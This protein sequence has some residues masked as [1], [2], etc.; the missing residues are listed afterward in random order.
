VS[1]VFTFRSHYWF[2][3]PGIAT[4]LGAQAG[5]VIYDFLIFTGKESIFNKP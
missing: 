3:C 5:V 1:S 4:T 2:W